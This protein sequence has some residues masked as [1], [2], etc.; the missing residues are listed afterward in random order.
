MTLTALTFHTLKNDFKWTLS[1]KSAKMADLKNL[2][3]RQNELADLINQIQSLHS[4]IFLQMFITGSLVI[5]VS[6]YE[7]MAAE[8]MA[9]TVIYFQFLAVFQ[10]IIDASESLLEGITDSDWYKIDDEKVKKMIPLLIQRAQK[11][12]FM[13]GK[14]FV[15]I[16]REAFSSV[17]RYMR[18]HCFKLTFT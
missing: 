17:S 18:N 10:K 1:D 13:T 4:M 2:I 8:K 6:S 14:G 11:I 16:S 9:D 12:A 5:C 3:D 15:V 7:A